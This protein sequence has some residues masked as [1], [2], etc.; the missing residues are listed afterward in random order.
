[1]SSQQLTHYSAIVD[2]AFYQRIPQ[3]AMQCGQVVRI[4]CIGQLVQVEDR[5]ALLSEEIENE[6]GA[7]KACASGN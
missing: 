3:V 6:I 2:V 5:L 1:M 4:A 7:N